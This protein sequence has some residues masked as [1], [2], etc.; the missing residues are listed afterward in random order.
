MEIIYRASRDGVSKDEFYKKCNLKANTI[1]I[2]QT[3]QN[4]VFGGFTSLK[5]LEPTRDIEVEHMKDPKAFV[6]IIRSSEGD[7]AKLYPVQHGGKNAIQHYVSGYL[8]FGTYGSAFYVDAIGD[9]SCIATEDNSCHEYNL[10]MYQLNGT[11]TDCEPVE[12][13]VFQLR[14]LNTATLSN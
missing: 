12:I 13:E 7:D 4:N 14:P 2:I 8:S 6:Y 10:K 5:W 9:I 11:V 1:C 3:P